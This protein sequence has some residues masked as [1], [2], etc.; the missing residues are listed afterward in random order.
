MT[1]V[2]VNADTDAGF[3]R[4][5]CHTIFPFQRGFTD[6]AV[7]FGIGKIF[8][9]GELEHQLRRKLSQYHRILK[10]FSIRDRYINLRWKNKEVP[11]STWYE[12][13]K[14]AHF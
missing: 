9:F 12:S 1:A 4:G 8:K 10:V 7:A 13:K 3:R 14:M 5:C 11:V 6:H 2:S